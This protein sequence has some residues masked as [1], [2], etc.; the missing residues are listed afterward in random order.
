MFTSLSAGSQSALSALSL[1]AAWP[2]ADARRFRRT[3]RLSLHHR[4]LQSQHQPQMAAADWLEAKACGSWVAVHDLFPKRQIKGRCPLTNVNITLVLH[5]KAVDQHEMIMPSYS[6]KI[7][8]FTKQLLRHTCSD[9]TTC[10]RKNNTAAPRQIKPTD[11]QHR[12]AH[13]LPF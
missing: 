13:T 10:K 9:R 12:D 7:S 2:P 8:T 1:P 11:R 6:A 4:S 5:E 3:S